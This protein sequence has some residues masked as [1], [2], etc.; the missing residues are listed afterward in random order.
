MPQYLVKPANSV[1]VVAEP[2]GIIEMKVGANATAAKMLPKRVVI[3]DAADGDVKESGDA[4]AAALGVL[5]EAPDQTITTAYALADPCRVARV[6]G[7]C[8]VLC[9][10]A[11]AAAG[12]TPGQKIVPAADGKVKASAAAADVTLGIAMST[13]AAGGPDADVMVAL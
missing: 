9:T 7:G 4:S 3:Y 12:C 1:L 13:V 11:S 6:G 8:I 10:F 2:L 5:L